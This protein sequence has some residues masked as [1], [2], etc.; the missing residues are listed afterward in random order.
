[1]VIE[2]TQHY[3]GLLAGRAQYAPGQYDTAKGDMPHALALHLLNTEQ[4]VEVKPAAS[5]KKPLSEEVEALA[6]L[7]EAS[8]DEDTSP[9]L[10]GKAS[11]RKSKGTA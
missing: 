5:A 3:S 4:A 1:M 2:L 11:R 10:P 9:A 6:T 8:D 7:N